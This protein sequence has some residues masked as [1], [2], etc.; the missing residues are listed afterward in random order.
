[1]PGIYDNM[2]LDAQAAFGFLVPQF[3]N[4][5]TTVYEVRY[6]EFDY[7]SIVPVVTEGNAWAAGTVFY[8]SDQTGAAQW[9]GGG[10]FDIPYADIQR[11]QLTAPFYMAAI[12]YE[13]N[14]EE[15]NRARM[16]GIDI[17]ADKARAARRA[18]EQFLW[19]LATTGNTEK[20]M[21]GL[22]NDANVS[23]ADVAANGSGNVTWW[24]DKTPAQILKDI[25][26][27]I[28][29]VYSSSN[30]TEMANTVIMP[31]AI[32]DYLASTQLSS[33]SDETIL[34]YLLKN[35]S[36]TAETDQPLLV[37]AN[38]AL[39]TADPGGD[40]RVV[41]YRRAPDVVRFHLPMPHQFL[42]PFQKA[43]MVWEV[44]GIMRAG[45][46]EVRLPGAIRYL[47]GVLNS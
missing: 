25:N 21:T 22:F 42:P 44:A 36:Y 28:S 7:A 47:D 32:R 18:A 13:W 34:S 20:N 26:D 30:E 27:G 11:T 12:G 41:I 19:Q 10:A 5:E 8:T 9:Q 43:S 45:G 33:G 37:R 6:P 38:R 31:T 4:L 24:Y 29:G 35:N 1:M 39:A 2:Q 3:Y 15:V 14:L 46:T 23:A 17:G 40:G 16:T